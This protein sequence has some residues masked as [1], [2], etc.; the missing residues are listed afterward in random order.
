MDKI[1]LLGMEFYGY[2]GVLPE[3]NALGQ[4]F[5]VDV[6]LCQSLQNAGR[7]DQIKETVNYA[8]VYEIVERIV[9]EK[10][11]QLIE[12]VA[13]VIASEIL[14]TYA[15]VSVDVRVAKEHPPIPG[16]IRQVAV[17]IHRMR[18]ALDE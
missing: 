16:H 15:V 2:H 1:E 9:A 11:F 17:S 13:E 18:E 7:T 6:V 14:S 12:T 4:R 8:E 10:R 3:E 5:T